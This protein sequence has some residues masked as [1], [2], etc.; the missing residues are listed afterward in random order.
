MC[1]PLLHRDIPPSKPRCVHF[2]RVIVRTH[3]TLLRTV[4]FVVCKTKTVRPLSRLGEGKSVLRSRRDP[5]HVRTQGPGT[6]ELRAGHRVGG[7]RTS[8][9]KNPFVKK[10]Q[11][12]K[13][14]TSQGTLY[15]IDFYTEFCGATIYGKGC[16]KGESQR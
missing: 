16:V 2:S 13:I 10:N 6:W 7:I 12:P 9:S 14:S 8:E 15:R 5:G 3:P 1:T 11:T 4:S